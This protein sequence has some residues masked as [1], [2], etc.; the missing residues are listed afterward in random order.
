[1]WLAPS[2][3]V[4]EERF[5]KGSFPYGRAGRALKPLLDG[6]DPEQIAAHLKRYLDKTN[7]QF[8]SLERFA[9]TFAEWNPLQT[10][11]DALSEPLVD[12]DGVLTEA[13]FRAIAQTGR[14][15]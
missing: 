9:I 1:M 2:K 4:W 3:A 8:V 13:G 5:G 12:E 11:F 14:R 6:A 15:Q 7:P 10:E